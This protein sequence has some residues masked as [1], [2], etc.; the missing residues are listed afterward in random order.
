MEKSYVLSATL[1]NGES[2]EYEYGVTSFS[3]VLDSGAHIIGGTVGFDQISPETQAIGMMVRL[4][5]SPGGAQAF[6]IYV[7]EKR[8]DKAHLTH[9]RANGQLL[10]KEVIDLPDDFDDFAVAVRTVNV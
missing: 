3:E 10:S 2:F 7:T 8:G 1:S 4:K 5:S 9:F 6:T